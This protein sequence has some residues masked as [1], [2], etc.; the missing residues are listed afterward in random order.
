MLEVLGA[1][2]LLASMELLVLYCFC[3]IWGLDCYLSRFTKLAWVYA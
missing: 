1:R 3:Y 2:H